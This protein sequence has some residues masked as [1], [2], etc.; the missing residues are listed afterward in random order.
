MVASAGSRSGCWWA[1]GELFHAACR[2]SG[3]RASSRSQQDR[4][5]RAKVED[6][7]LADA[8]PRE[9]LVHDNIQSCVAGTVNQ[10]QALVG[11][12][13]HHDWHTWNKREN[14]WHRNGTVIALLQHHQHVFFRGFTTFPPVLRDEDSQFPFPLGLK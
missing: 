2:R 3:D 13:I 4:R 6:D 12:F 10:L 7:V 8:I 9:F 5:W 14:G 11:I 1:S